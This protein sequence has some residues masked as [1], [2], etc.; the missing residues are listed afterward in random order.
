M[1]N[2]SALWVFVGTIC[3]FMVITMVSLNFATGLL[4]E[5]KHLKEVIATMEKEKEDG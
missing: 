4:E 5:N 2:D 3:V 1:K